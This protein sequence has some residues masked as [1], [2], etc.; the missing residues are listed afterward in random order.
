M[1]LRPARFLPVL[2]PLA[3]VA[4]CVPL[5]E[6][7]LRVA[8]PPMRFYV[9]HPSNVR[10]FQPSEVSTPGVSGLSRFTTNSL[11]LRGPEL[12]DERHRLLV[13][14][15]S[16]AACTALD[17]GEAWPEVMRERVNALTH[18]PRFLWVANAGVDGKASRHHLMQATY[19]LP[20]LPKLDHVLVYA[21]LNDVGHWLYNSSIDPDE[22]ERPRFWDDTVAETFRLSRYSASDAKWFR[23]LELYR[24]VSLARAAI[25]T[26]LGDDFRRH[27]V[28]VQDDQMAWMENAQAVRSGGQ[29]SLVATPKMETLPLALGMYRRTLERTVAQIRKNGAQP[30]LMTQAIQWQNL[31]EDE[32]KRLWMGAMDG[33]KA[34]A[35][36]AQ[37]EELVATF[38]REMV[39][40]AA[41]EGVP[42]IDLPRLLD[43]ERKLFFDGCHFNERGARRVGEVVAQHMVEQVFRAAPA[44]DRAAIVGTQR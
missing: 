29:I 28:L 5:L 24:Y 32:K 11:G 1:A 17:D 44:G 6:V 41:A 42:L 19:L 7:A 14:G 34:Y 16:T 36:E 3:V 4:L 12:G 26:R 31:D 2:V 15:G 39:A 37:M 9:Y 38:N 8:A 21:G 30:I 23:K 27:D 33:G 35:S 40:V 22:L 43:G 20:E 10:V 13:M 25:T 18:D